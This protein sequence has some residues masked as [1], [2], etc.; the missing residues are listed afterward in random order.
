MLGHSI[1]TDVSQCP[2]TASETRCSICTA[3]PKFG[4]LIAVIF[5]EASGSQ[6]LVLFSRN[7]VPG[8]ADEQHAPLCTA[9]TANS[10]KEGR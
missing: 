10:S 6:G 4:Q 7:R 5:M 2:Q 3:A 8:Q 1:V 9:A